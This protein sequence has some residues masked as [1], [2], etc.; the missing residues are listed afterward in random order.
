MRLIKVLLIV[1]FLLF[2]NILK[3]QDLKELEQ[4]LN[5]SV[6]TTKITA[7]ITRN[8]KLNPLKISVSTVD[9]I[10]ELSGS[11]EDANAFFEVIRLVKETKGVKHVNTDELQIKHVNTKFTDIYLTAKVQAQILTAKLLDDESIPLVGIN[12]TT[13]N[14]IVTLTGEIENKKALLVI[15]KRISRIH[16][17]KQVVSNLIIRESANE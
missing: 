5:D 2:S 15:L 17:V 3:A 8:F 9:G 1:L 13:E 16:G 4:D 11:V 7:K 6:I 10:V 12:A 14:G